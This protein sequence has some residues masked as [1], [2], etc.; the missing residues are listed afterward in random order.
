MVTYAYRQDWKTWLFVKREKHY[1]MT[2]KQEYRLQ[3][4]SAEQ[5]SGESNTYLFALLIL[6]RPWG[7]SKEHD[8]I[9]EKH[10]FKLNK[11]QNEFWSVSWE[12]LLKTM[13]FYLS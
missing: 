4:T 12:R 8:E 5:T 6:R 10:D 13:G 1:I 7:Q 9:C 2:Y 3:D 11:R